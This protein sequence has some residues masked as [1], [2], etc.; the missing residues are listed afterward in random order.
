[1]PKRLT[2][3]LALVLGSVLSQV[4]VPRHS[5]LHWLV[6]EGTADDARTRLVGIAGT[7]I[8]VIALMLGLTCLAGRLRTSTAGV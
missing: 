3:V 5:F 2:V 4:T 7:M 1:V 6:F 8:T